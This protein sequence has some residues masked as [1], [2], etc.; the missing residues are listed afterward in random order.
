M[1]KVTQG[2][3]EI[4]WNPEHV[5]LAKQSISEVLNIPKSGV[6][7]NEFIEVDR[8]TSN[9]INSRYSELV[10]E[11]YPQEEVPYIPSNEERLEALEMALLE[12]L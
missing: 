12:L 10:E 4:K 3:I 9:E 8:E 6:V 11:K 1:Y 7:E 2:R 5:D